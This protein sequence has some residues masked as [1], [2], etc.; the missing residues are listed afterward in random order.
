MIDV[1]EI[2]VELL[3][4][5]RAG[6]PVKLITE[7]YPELDWPTARAIARA[8]D[9]LRRVDGEVQVGY[10]L[11]WT[12][13]VMRQALGVDR[14]N[15]GTLWQHQLLDSG[16]TIDLSG[17]IHPKLEPELVWRDGEW[18]L[19]IEVVD[20]RFPSY[21]FDALDNTADNSSSALV[22]VGEFRPL[23]AE[24]VADIEIEIT[25]GCDRRGGRAD[26]AMGSPVEAVGWLRRSLAAEGLALR[27]G[28]IVF[29]GGLAAP[30][31]LE[32][33]DEYVL[34]T[35]LLAPVRCSAA[36]I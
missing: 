22:V 21:G 5:A 8:T 20:P 9:E 6:V 27:P 3:A 11:G 2:A 32:P 14:P 16:A 35:E 15:W 34:T 4:A 31:D 13:A 18:A 29:T 1:G 7:R 36:E 25:N 10:K 12:S 26:A 23:A 17:L 28:D 30:Y 19:G 33:D 24:L